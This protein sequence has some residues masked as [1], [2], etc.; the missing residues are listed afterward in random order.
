[1]G[2]AA[3]EVRFWVEV[4]GV[5]GV[6]KGVNRFTIAFL[7]QQHDAEIVLGFG[8]LLMLCNGFFQVRLGGWQFPLLCQ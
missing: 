1:M 8:P 5:C 6:F 4:A 3:V 7:T 2:I